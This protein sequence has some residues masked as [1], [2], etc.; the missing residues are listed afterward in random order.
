MVGFWIRRLG[1]L[2]TVLSPAPIRRVLRPCSGGTVFGRHRVCWC[3]GQ[4]DRRSADG[5]RL[6]EWCGFPGSEH[7]IVDVK[8]H[9]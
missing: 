2:V 4:R 9:L 5:E 8:G 7:R 3:V 1:V 6:V